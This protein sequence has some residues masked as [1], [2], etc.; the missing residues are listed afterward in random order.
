MHPNRA[1]HGDDEDAVPDADW[2]GV[3]RQFGSGDRAPMLPDLC[4]FQP[5]PQIRGRLEFLERDIGLR[6]RVEAALSEPFAGTWPRAEAG[7]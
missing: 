5:P 3:G 7:R 1:V 4:L 6:V 2:R